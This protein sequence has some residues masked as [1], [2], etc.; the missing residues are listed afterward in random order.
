M[1]SPSS[2]RASSG[3]QID[4]TATFVYVAIDKGGQNKERVSLDMRILEL[5]FTEGGKKANRFK[6]VVEDFLLKNSETKQ[7]V[8]GGVLVLQWG[9]VGNPG[10]EYRGVIQ[11]VKG[12]QKLEIEGLAKTVLMHK[13]KRSR[14][15]NNMK[16]SDV[17]KQVLKEN[18]Y[19]TQDLDIEDTEITHETI[20]QVRQTDAEFIQG[21]AAEDDL[22][23]GADFD[24]FHF[25]R[26]TFEASPIR[27]YTFYTSTAG[28]I[29]K[30]SVD[31]Q[32]GVIA[33]NVSIKTV[34]PQTGKVV[35]QKGSDADTKRGGTSSQ[36]TRT[37]AFQKSQDAQGEFSLGASVIKAAPNPATAKRQADKAYIS[38]T[39]RNFKL[40]MEIPGDPNCM[41]K[42]VLTVSNIGKEES[43]RYYSNIVEHHVKGG[44]FTHKI[45][46][47]SDHEGNGEASK[48]KINPGSAD[49]NKLQ[50]RKA[51]ID[52]QTATLRKN[53]GRV[54]ANQ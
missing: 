9:Y 29:L 31:G 40:K 7:F 21:M 54:Y 39:R 1:P 2:N 22:E 37:R 8:K 42:T 10:P 33:S 19:Q 18:G 24:G 17:V 15:F 13:E 3:T 32:L 28:D 35:E 23:W 16:H 41:S 50:I 6:I 51:A 20:N 11:K 27:E 5:K 45:E 25:R 47:K 26:P 43:G 46:G 52:E 34:D 38:G 12:N 44:K 4:R 48:A 36:V 49:P 30:Y 53:N 14:V